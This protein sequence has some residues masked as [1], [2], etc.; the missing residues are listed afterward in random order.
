MLH[1]ADVWLCHKTMLR[2]PYYES[3]RGV[4]KFVKMGGSSIS[5]LQPCKYLLGMDC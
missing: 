4:G 2:L 1:F 5:L 3:Q